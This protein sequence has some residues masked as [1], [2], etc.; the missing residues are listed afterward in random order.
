MP[1]AVT[2]TVLLSSEAWQLAQGHFEQLRRDDLVESDFM[3]GLEDERM[4]IGDWFD[5]LGGGQWF[6]L[7]M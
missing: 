6:V 4:E 3:C 7:S 2:R 1:N 5:E